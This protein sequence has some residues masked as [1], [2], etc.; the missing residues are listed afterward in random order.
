MFSSNEFDNLV[1]CVGSFF[2]IKIALSCIGEFLRGSGSET[3]WTE[4][5]IF[6]MNVNKF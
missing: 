2:M 5:S 4:C 1:P 3:I 6:G